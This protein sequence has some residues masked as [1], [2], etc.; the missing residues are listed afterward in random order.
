MSTVHELLATDETFH[1]VAD[2]LFGGG[3]DQ[4][5]A[6][7]NPA[8]SDLAAKDR[9]KRKITAG[10]SAVGAAA[11]GAG[12]ALGTHNVRRGYKA[13]RAAQKSQ[14]LYHA[15]G[16][17]KKALKTAI[18]HEKLATG[19]VPLEVAGL[20]GEIAATKILHGDTKKK[21]GTLVKK[22]QSEIC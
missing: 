14:H 21:P 10:L 18:G 15:A 8:Q 1:D 17:K 7:M 19:L 2:L 3:G 20:T 12:L 13:A 22:S 11:G 6:K 4:L 9:Q 5:I 16:A